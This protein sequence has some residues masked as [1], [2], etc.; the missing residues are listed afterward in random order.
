MNIMKLYKYYGIKD[1]INKELPIELRYPLS[2]VTSNDILAKDFENTRN[3]SKYIKIV[4][5]VSKKEGCRYL[6]EN[7]SCCLCD[8]SLFMTIKDG[9]IESI[10]VP[11]TWY[12]YTTVIDLINMFF[13][14]SFTA[15]VDCSVFNNDYKNALDIIKYT[16]LHSNPTTMCDENH[17]DI[18]FDEFAIFIKEFRPLLKL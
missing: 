13:I 11:H 15:K 14:E 7:D 18:L 2:A 9:E 10:Y 4:S 1:T 6:N 12:E 16:Q 3:M 8:E 17:P 5:K